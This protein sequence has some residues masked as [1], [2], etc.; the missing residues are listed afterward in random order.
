MKTLLQSRRGHRIDSHTMLI[1]LVKAHD[2][3]KNEVMSVALRKMGV[4]ERCIKWAMK[5]HGD[6]DAVPKIGGEEIS[7]KMFVGYDRVT[8]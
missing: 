2:S 8:T 5:L 7:I 4:P 3:I 6:F 1:D